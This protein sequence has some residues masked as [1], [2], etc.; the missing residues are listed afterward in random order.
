M[1]FS[2]NVIWTFGARLAMV[3]NSV[4][5]GIVV[6]R[7]L[8]ADGVGKLAVINVSVITLV[9]L[10]SLGLPSANTYF[11]AKDPEQFRKT[12]INSTLFALF[13]GSLLA[14]GLA[15]SAQL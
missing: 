8:G 11:I 5:A 1:R 2:K 13:A 9:Q 7:W 3:V 4:L 6:A 12:T 10:G 14:L 15:A